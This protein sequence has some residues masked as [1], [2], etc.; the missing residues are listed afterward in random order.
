M[1]DV[2]MELKDLVNIKDSLKKKEECCKI[3]LK[4]IAKAKIKIN[5]LLKEHSG[6]SNV[7]IY[8]PSNTFENLR[9]VAGNGKQNFNWKKIAYEIINKNQE[10][11]STLMIYEKARLLHP[12]ELSDRSKSI[13]G[14]SAALS[15]LKK[16]KKIIAEIIDEK[17][18]YTIKK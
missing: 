13:H 9:Q 2:K 12:I 17:H 4:N 1:S 3:V 7:I 6:N 15:L 8:L 11:M 5:A 10:K 18:F 14:F 16:E